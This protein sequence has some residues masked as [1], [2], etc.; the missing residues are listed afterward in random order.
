MRS[1]VQWQLVVRVVEERLDLSTRPARQKIS[2]N[3]FRW[4]LEYE[5]SENNNNRTPFLQKKQDQLFAQA[6]LIDLQGTGKSQYFAQ[7]CPIIVNY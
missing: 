5:V 4:Y 3:V 1:F 7:P 2:P 6:E